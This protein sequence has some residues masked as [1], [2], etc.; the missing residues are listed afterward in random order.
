MGASPLEFCTG[1]RA[2]PRK[3]ARKL[4]ARKE[5]DGGGVIGSEQS[6]EGNRNSAFLFS[7]RT[8]CI[9]G[10]CITG[11]ESTRE[12]ERLLSAGTLDRSVDRGLGGRRAHLHIVQLTFDGSQLLDWAVWI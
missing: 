12:A 11:E 6:V 3:T 10:V 4:K 1:R 7:L 2:F 8:T 9:K 5:R